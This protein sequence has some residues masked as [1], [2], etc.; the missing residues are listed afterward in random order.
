M[1][2][3]RT[4]LILFLEHA[5]LNI[6]LAAVN[7]ARQACMTASGA[8]VAAC[9]ST[10]E[11]GRSSQ[12]P[13]LDISK[14]SLTKWAGCSLEVQ[15]Y[16]VERLE[17]AVPFQNAIGLLSQAPFPFDCLS[18]IRTLRSARLVLIFLLKGQG[19]RQRQHSA[20]YGLP[21]AR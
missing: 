1:F 5:S 6:M 14:H 19:G 13:N 2:E 8:A 12:A 10:G 20:R 21:V 15:K 4:R 18:L 17:L 11:G 9:K 7:Q 16:V 3:C